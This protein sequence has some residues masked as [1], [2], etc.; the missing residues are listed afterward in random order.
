MLPS[1]TAQQPKERPDR[2]SKGS[3]ELRETEITGSLRDI[4][5]AFK[6]HETEIVGMTDQPRFNYMLP[7]QDPDPFPGEETDLARGLIEQSF[8]PFEPEWYGREVPTRT[9]P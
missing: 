7:W 4:V 1:A 8:S 9:G 2:A 3:V 5:G 6:L